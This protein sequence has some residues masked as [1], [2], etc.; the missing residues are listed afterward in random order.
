MSRIVFQ[1]TGQQILPQG[2][3]VEASVH[4]DKLS[5]VTLTSVADGEV[6]QYDSASGKFIN[7][8]ISTLVSDELDEIDGVT[9]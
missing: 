5:D 3:D 1:G 9:Y 7:V 2:E 4:L 8:S 6:L